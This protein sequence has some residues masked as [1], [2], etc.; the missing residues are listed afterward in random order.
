MDVSS[1]NLLNVL[2][3]NSEEETEVLDGGR[4]CKAVST[5]TRIRRGLSIDL[6][7]PSFWFTPFV[8]LLAETDPHS[9]G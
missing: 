1:F 9:L 2:L 8:S 5:G 3:G 4:I 6:G 7:S